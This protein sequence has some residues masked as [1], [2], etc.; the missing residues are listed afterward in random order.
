M[1]LVPG[2][3]NDFLTHQLSIFLFCMLRFGC[4]MPCYSGSSSATSQLFLE[5]ACTKC[6]FSIAIGVNVIVC[7]VLLVRLTKLA[8]SRHH[9]SISLGTSCCCDSQWCI[10]LLQ[11]CTLKRLDYP[12]L[13]CHSLSTVVTM[14]SRYFSIWVHWEA[15]NPVCITLHTWQAS[16]HDSW[17]ITQ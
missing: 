10:L 12:S 2:L 15:S 5:K 3:K 17:Q 7:A 16:T 1:L 14:H 11:Q 4:G 6:A 9:F 13:F 8:R